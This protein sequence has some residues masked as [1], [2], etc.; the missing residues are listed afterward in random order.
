[1]RSERRAF[2]AAQGDA[3][4]GLL[5]RHPPRPVLDRIAPDAVIGLYRA[6]PD[7]APT[8]HYAAFFFERGHRIALPR[9]GDRAAPMQFALHEDP[10]AQTDLEPGPFGISQPS[11]D[12]QNIRPDV[13]FVPLLAFTANGDRLGQGGGHYDR[14]MADN[15]PALS[16]GMAW[17]MQE[18]ER[19]PVEPHDKALDLIV[20]PTR[21]IGGVDA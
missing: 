10:I 19:L 14:W 12:A 9:F 5:F 8:D 13:L 21:L 16:I 3:M 2:A 6:T 4:R 18:T 17:D 7:E 11:A 15:P 20:T 1:M